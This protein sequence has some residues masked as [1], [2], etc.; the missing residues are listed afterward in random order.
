MGERLNN[1]ALIAVVGGNSCSPQEALTAYAVGK[2]LAEKGYGVV[3]GGLGGVMEHA[4]RGAQEA[5]GM[6]IGILPGMDAGDANP[7]VRV[8]IPTGM[9]EMRNALVVRSAQ[10]VIAIGGEYGTLSEIAFALKTGKRVV[11]ID[12]WELRKKDRIDQ[13]I[14]KAAT[15]EEAVELAIAGLQV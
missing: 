3:C 14:V 6:A 7:Y 13:G 4:C 15:P 8:A 11:G 2:L 1:I 12:T 10:A 9:G 5:G